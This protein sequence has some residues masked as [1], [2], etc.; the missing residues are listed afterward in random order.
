MSTIE[1]MTIALP[2]EM[3]ESVRSAIAA[4]DYASSN[5]LFHDALLAW[6][7]K[8]ICQEQELVAIDV[9][10]SQGLG[11]LQAGNIKSSETVLSRLEHK[12]RAMSEIP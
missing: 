11:D 8:R 2:V 10:I 4:G 12:Y 6:K 9:G 3:A 7:Q 1:R 5:E